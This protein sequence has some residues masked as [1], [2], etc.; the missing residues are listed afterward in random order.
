MCFDPPP[1]H[2][3]PDQVLKKFLPKLRYT[4]KRLEVTASSK[5]WTSHPKQHPLLHLYPGPRSDF[6]NRRKGLC[7][8]LSTSLT[9]CYPPPKS[10]K[11]S[12]SL[13]HPDL[14]PPG[15]P[16]EVLRG[17]SVRPVP[18]PSVYPPYHT[19]INRPRAKGKTFTKGISTPS[20]VR[21]PRFYLV[22]YHR[23]LSP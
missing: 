15:L 4:K 21:S 18:F 8:R 5:L 13:L 9:R 19:R 14:I 10:F 6:T 3:T 12:P 1:Q 7:H 11:R 17:S 20:K 2:E 16:R 23:R 22:F